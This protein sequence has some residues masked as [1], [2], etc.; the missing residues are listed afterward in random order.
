[1]DYSLSQLQSMSNGELY[2]HW[3]F[4]RFPFDLGGCD[5]C[6]T[7]HNDNNVACATPDAHRAVRERISQLGFKGREFDIKT[8]RENLEEMFALRSYADT[9]DL[10][11]V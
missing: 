2:A 6:L 11:A 8:A 3:Q 4:S 9:F 5:Q 10:V 7:M 1:M